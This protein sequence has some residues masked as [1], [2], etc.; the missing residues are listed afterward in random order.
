MPAKV[1]GLLPTSQHCT[2]H[3]FDLF[4]MSTSDEVWLDLDVDSP[5]NWIFAWADEF[6][7]SRGAINSILQNGLTR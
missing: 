4:V 5:G 7:I 6:G 2:N 1:K 3:Q